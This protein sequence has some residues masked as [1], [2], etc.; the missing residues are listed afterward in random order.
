VNE[1]VTNAVKFAFPDDTKGTVL[2]RLKRASGE[3]RLMVADDGRGLD[4]GRADCG[5]GGRLV[6][7]FAQQLG[8]QLKRES[9]NLRGARL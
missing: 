9:G 8:G 4:P 1:L 2:V 3:L 5:L 6:E 7:G